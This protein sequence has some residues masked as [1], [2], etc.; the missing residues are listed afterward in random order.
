MKNIKLQADSSRGSED[1]RRWQAAIDAQPSDEAFLVYGD[2]L[3]DQGDARGELV[4]V[5]KELLHE[6]WGEGGRRLRARRAKLLDEHKDQLLGLLAGHKDL[7]LDL[8]WHLGF[9]S[10]MVIGAQSKT[11]DG[12]HT[13]LSAVFAHPSAR[14]L[15]SLEIGPV[16]CGDEFSLSP[17]IEA[18]SATTWPTLRRLVLG[19]PKDGQWPAGAPVDTLLQQMPS[20]MHLELNCEARQLPSFA[21]ATLRELH[22]NIQG[23]EAE[24]FSLVQTCPSLE[25]F[26]IS[27]A[28]SELIAETVA[29]LAKLPPRIRELGLLCMEDGDDL[30]QVISLEHCEHLVLSMGGITDVGVLALE[31]RMDQLGSVT[32]LDLRDNCIEGTIDALEERFEVKLGPQDAQT[33]D[34]RMLPGRARAAFLTRRRHGR[35]L[36]RTLDHAGALPYFESAQRIAR[37]NGN[38]DDESAAIKD[39]G[40]LTYNLGQLDASIEHREAYLWRS[41]GSIQA[42][43]DLATSYRSRGRNY[44]AEEIFEDA[45]EIVAKEQTVSSPSGKDA[46]SAR[47]QT[48][49]LEA[50]LWVEVA[51]TRINMGNWRGAEKLCLHA[52]AYEQKHDCETTRTWNILGGVQAQGARHVDAAKSFERALALEER[53]HNKIV[54]E[55]NLGQAEWLAGQRARAAARY[56][57]AADKANALGIERV[58]GSALSQL[59]HLY[60]NWGKNSE[61]KEVLLRALPL[62]EKT[63]CRDREG[64]TWG[65]LAIVLT[66]QQKLDEAEEAYGKAIEIHRATGNK[67]AFAGSLI[68]LAGVFIDRGDLDG[69][70]RTCH[71]A[72]TVQKELGD[73]WGQGT[74]SSQLGEVFLARGDDKAAME[75]F[76]RARRLSA[77]VNNH[78]WNTWNQFKCGQVH[79]ACGET[80]KA[81]KLFARA[82]ADLRKIGDP[83]MLGRLLT[84]VALLRAIKREDRAADVLAEAREH[85]QA[86]G[87]VLGL[88]EAKAV[89]QFIAHLERGSEPPAGNLYAD[90]LQRCLSNAP[91]RPS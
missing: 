51:A 1:A 69:C 67:R 83:S 22:L 39:L 47:Q 32:N 78:R 79:L 50:K 54:I 35:E 77:S 71:E 66:A 88:N 5:D 2:W 40:A 57:S 14:F 44:R 11:H 30:C 64:E 74:S 12:L 46:S 73:R 82:E 3:Q 36:W 37:A 10:E 28:G 17:I 48:D 6:P 4:A 24:H 27:L 18:L 29:R 16:R 42:M 70:E 59:G 85:L 60:T 90:F 9:I 52:N 8:H 89:D 33:E 20:L 49:H 86:A 68:H 41:G 55:L 61:A 63:Q 58:E 84:H 34:P 87:D 45:L 62:L 91:K 80:Q 23:A 7:T 76:K 15:R 38:H 75:H 31:E 56:Q 25:R 81:R 43:I 21:H 19:R 72:L 26:T 65:H 13:L 53:E